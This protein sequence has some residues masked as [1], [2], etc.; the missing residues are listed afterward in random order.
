ME[1]KQ[2]NAPTAEIV[3][4]QAENPLAAGTTIDLDNTK[5]AWEEAGSKSADDFDDDFADD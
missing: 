5:E 3:R 2:Y 1:K 4:V